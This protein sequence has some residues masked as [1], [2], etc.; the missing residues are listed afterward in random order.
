[1]FLN[2]FNLKRTALLC[3]V[4][5]TFSCASIACKKKI[6]NVESSGGDT[7]TIGVKKEYRWEK[8]DLTVCWLN[9]NPY[10]N[11]FKRTRKEIVTKN[12]HKTVFRLSGWGVCDR[13][14]RAVR[15]DVRIFIYDDP[16]AETDPW[17]RSAFEHAEANGDGTPGREGGYLATLGINKIYTL[18][19]NA[20][21]K[22]GIPEKS[23]KRFASLNQ[24][25]KYNRL[26]RTVL[27]EFGHILG[28]EHEN[29]HEEASCH[30]EKGET[31]NT[32]SSEIVAPYNKDSVMSYCNHRFETLET[33]SEPNFTPGDV[34][35]INRMYAHLKTP[36]ASL[37]K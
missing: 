12:V 21:Y 31:L 14:E 30:S 3:S 4:L 26:T 25:G 18:L 32:E 5:A 28:L 22:K 13:S 36:K 16:K 27:H 17:L 35:G 24:K 33:D 2:R 11:E 20:E 29:I 1:M 34:L 9:D 7:Q 37:S 8:T 23:I 15:A 6:A 10:Y 19:L